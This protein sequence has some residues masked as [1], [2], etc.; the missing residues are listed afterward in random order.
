MP[1]IRFEGVRLQLRRTLTK[2]NCH[3]ERS[4]CRKAMPTQSKDLEEAGASENSA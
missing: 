3:P 2:A 4:W 1:E